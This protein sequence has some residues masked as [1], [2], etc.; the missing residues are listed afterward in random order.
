MAP[1]RI[2]SAHHDRELLTVCLGERLDADEVALAL[3]VLQQRAEEIGLSTSPERC[4]W[5][6]TTTEITVV[7]PD[8]SAFELQR[9]LSSLG[10]L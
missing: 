4:V 8:G 10:A 6:L 2:L 5:R 7:V 3:D 1:H 9:R